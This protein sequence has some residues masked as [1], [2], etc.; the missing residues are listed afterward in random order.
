MKAMKDAVRPGDKAAELR[1]L[2]DKEHRT[3]QWA[4]DR[5]QSVSRT[6][7][8]ML[9][10]HTAIT[11]L[12]TDEVP[13][14]ME[15]DI[16]RIAATKFRCLAAMQV[17]AKF[18]SRQLADVERLVERCASGRASDTA[19]RPFPA[20]HPA[21]APSAAGT[22]AH[23]ASRTLTTSRGR[24]RRICRRRRRPRRPSTRA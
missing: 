4:S 14:E 7:H 20:P 8:G 11:H 24:R 19:R 17:Y 21:P 13:K 2:A 15:K 9:K 16:E 23:C 12:L 22:R 5:W 18:D 10:C 6:L 3:R 1:M